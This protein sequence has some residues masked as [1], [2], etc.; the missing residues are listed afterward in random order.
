MGIVLAASSATP[1]SANVL[2]VLG[3][4]AAGATAFFVMRWLGKVL[5]AVL[6]IAAVIFLVCKAIK[7]VG[8]AVW[9]VLS[10]IRRFWRTSA[11]VLAL[12]YLVSLVGWVPLVIALVTAALGCVVWWHEHVTTFERF[13]SRRLRSWWLRWTIYQPRWK[14]WVRSCGL[15]VYARGENLAEL[16]LP[17]IKAVRSGPSWDEVIVRLVP[18]LTVEDVEQSTRA[19]AVARGA[20]RCLVRQLGPSTVSLDFQRRDVLASLVDCATLDVDAAGTDVDL[21]RVYAGLSEYSRPWHVPLLACHWLV[22]AESRAGKNSFTWQV[23]R[24]VAPAL[25]DGLV[26][27]HAI[28]PKGVELAYGRK[29]FTTYTDTAAG[30]LELLDHLIDI[31][32]A[33]KAELRGKARK[34]VISREQPL[35]L[36]EF[37]EIAALSKYAGSQVKAKLDQR[38]GL[39]LTQ[40]AALG[41]CLRGY[42]QDPAKDTVAFR[43]LF[44]RRLCLR[45]PTEQQVDMVL[46][47]DAVK[48]GAWAHR[49]PQ[50]PQGKGVGYVFG[51]GVREPM[52]V[53]IG[54]N[55]DP[56][57]KELEQYV[58]A[59]GQVLALPAAGQTDAV[60]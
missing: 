35:H 4:V 44:T 25:R 47:D 24:S 2:L 52:R 16:G 30:A 1:G 57:I 46:G 6:E 43:D 19:L 26:V 54:W 9:W 32:N 33:R 41:V 37:D 40:A 29:V 50:T 21:E 59:R 22:G 38:V 45:V 51:E 23:L 55:S 48:R 12:A 31:A 18:G 36:V 27:A 5:A 28:D 15:A 11:G 20:D 8:V 56:S 3:V 53:R 10:T 7:S 42:V 14:N 13:I 49:I 60:A 17:S 58:T 34:V 39:L